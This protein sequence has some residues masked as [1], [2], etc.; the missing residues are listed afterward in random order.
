MFETLLNGILRRKIYALVNFTIAAIAIG[1]LRSDILLGFNSLIFILSVVFIAIL[2]AEL[3]LLPF[4]KSSSPKWFIIGL[5]I[6]IGLVLYLSI[7]VQLRFLLTFLPI[8]SFGVAMLM[9]GMSFYNKYI[10]NHKG[11]H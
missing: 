11:K 3:I 4:G 10:E 8:V 6:T 7:F 1:V 5:F 2:I 9:I